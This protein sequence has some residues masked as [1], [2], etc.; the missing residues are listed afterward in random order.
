V[1]R[2][3]PKTPR[4]STASAMPNSR[5]RRVSPRGK[6][7]RILP[8]HS[9]ASAAQRRGPS[10]KSWESHRA[11]ARGQDETVRRLR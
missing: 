9:A 2:P 8:V 4:I 11:G 7:G 3:A 5:L 6:E 1:A 10:G